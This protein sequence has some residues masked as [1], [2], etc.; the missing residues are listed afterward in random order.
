MLHPFLFDKS[1][2]MYFLCSQFYSD[3][4]MLVSSSM[5]V[6]ERPSERAHFEILH[7]EHRYFLICFAWRS[8]L[9]NI[10]CYQILL[11]ITWYHDTRPLT[12]AGHTGNWSI[13][14]RNN[15]R[16][17]WGTFT[18]ILVCKLVSFP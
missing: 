14:E 15:F 8:V 13:T 6:R 7:A 17:N 12:H 2:S 5:S 4:A 18:A 11:F 1:Q 10:C 9:W 3:I 16:R